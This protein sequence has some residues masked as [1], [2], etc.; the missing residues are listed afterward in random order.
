MDTG[1][2]VKL[3]EVVVGK[4]V[5]DETLERNTKIPLKDESSEQRTRQARSDAS[6]LDSLKKEFERR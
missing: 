6:V 5:P 1:K 3:S 4:M 2:W